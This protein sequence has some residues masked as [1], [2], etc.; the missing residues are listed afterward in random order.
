MQ[1]TEWMMC[2]EWNCTENQRVL[3]FVEKKDEGDVRRNEG[4]GS[5]IPMIKSRGNAV[6]KKKYAKESQEV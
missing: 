4:Q 2:F 1:Q 6:R 5:E 3:K